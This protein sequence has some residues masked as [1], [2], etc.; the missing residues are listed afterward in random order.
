MRIELLDHGYMELVKDPENG[1]EQFWGSDSVIISRARMST[2]GAFR[3]W[4]PIP[5]ADCVSDGRAVAG[6]PDRPQLYKSYDHF[7]DA[8]QVCKCKGLNCVE[9]DEKL[10]RHLWVEKHSTPFEMAGFT[11]EVQLPIFVA[12]EW[13]RHRT[14]SYSEM[15]GRYVELPKLCYIPSEERMQI[16]G[17]S[18]SNKQGSGVAL[19]DITVQL[20]RDRFFINYDE[21]WDNYQM[22]L[23]RGVAREL[24][25]RV[26]PLNQYT[27]MSATGNLRNW[28]HFLNLRLA[29]NAQ[30]EIRQ[31]AQAVDKLVESL[32]P[33]TW[34]LFHHGESR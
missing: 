10:L 25:S 23:N 5:C 18:K 3:G 6:G 28:L 29:S 11:I 32:F 34:A 14:Q 9:G 30:W 19:S 16:G 8:E 20:S 13:Q 17:Q 1:R 15:S 2:D 33:L 27:R 24:A 7:K 4:G 21:A 31:Y 26:L 22:M 12:R